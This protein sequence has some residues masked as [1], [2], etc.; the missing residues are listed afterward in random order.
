MK[1]QEQVAFCDEIDGGTSYQWYHPPCV[2]GRD[3][4]PGI[5]LEGVPLERVPGHVTCA[6]CGM[7]I[8][9]CPYQPQDVVNV[10]PTQWGYYK[11]RYVL[12]LVMS[13][14][15]QCGWY[16]DTGQ[17][18]EDPYGEEALALS[19]VK[20][21]SIPAFDTSPSKRPWSRPNPFYAS[22][23]ERT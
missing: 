2:E 12:V 17:R 15:S 9:P 19:P 21:Y 22:K 23:G 6:S 13:F 20:V 8:H 7:P 5:P 11:A 3:L 1:G 18:L 16:I 4:S 10:H 14:S